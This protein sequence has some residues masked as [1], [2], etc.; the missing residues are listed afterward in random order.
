VV[1]GAVDVE[2]GNAIAIEVAIRLEVTGLHIV[3][4]AVCFRHATMSQKGCGGLIVGAEV[5]SA[6]E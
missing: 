1:I 5:V 4:D 6:T 2:P 3:E